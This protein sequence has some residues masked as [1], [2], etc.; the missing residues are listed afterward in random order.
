VL[1]EDV[2]WLLKL[3]GPKVRS[4]LAGRHREL[5]LDDK[6]IA[7]A[8]RAFA[9]ALAGR[10]HLTRPE[11]GDVLRRRGIAPD[12]QRLPHLLL[13]AE[14]DGL[15]ISGPRRGKQ[16]T[17]ALM[18]ERAPKARILDRP[19]AIAE[20]TLRYFRSHGPAQLKDFA[21]WSGLTLGDARKGI[22]LTK[23]SIAH[24][25]I[26]GND[27]WFDAA[28]GPAPA[29]TGVA[30]LLPN[31]DEYTVAYRDRAALIHPDHPVDLAIFAFRSIFAN[32]V[33]VGGRVRGSWRRS[34]AGGAQVE[35]R[36]LDRLAA[37][38]AAA[39]KQ[40]GRRLGRFLERPVTLVEQGSS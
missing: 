12:G 40:A 39:L 9:A 30:H 29:A 7:R 14:L 38:E 18:A 28:A 20:L 3:T 15:I 1:P 32:V 27:Y 21:W 33:V 5:E 10:N 31:F 6:V 16:L 24:H 26:D 23:D 19:E 36:M 35:I 11:L 25:S 4:G 34:P 17:Y 8:G 2:H 37:R 13:C 22:S